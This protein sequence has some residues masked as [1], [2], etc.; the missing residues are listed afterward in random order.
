METKTT[1]IKAVWVDTGLPLVNF[2][3]EGLAIEGIHRDPTPEEIEATRTFL[4]GETSVDAVLCLQRVYAPGMPLRDRTGMDVRVGRHLPMRGNQYMRDHLEHALNNADPWSLHVAFEV[5]HPFMDGNGRTGRT[6][7]AAAMIESGQ[8]PFA[9]SF[10]HR[11]YYQT[12]D[13]ADGR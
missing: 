12:L 3:R 6:V 9:L 5:L 4:C 11:F 10:L 2:L 13:H 1:R 8:D 7:W